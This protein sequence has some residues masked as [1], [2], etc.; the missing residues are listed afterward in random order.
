[1]A[2]ISKVPVAWNGS[3]VVGT[4]YS[5]LYCMAGDEH[6]LMTAFRALLSTCANSF[7]N[8]LQWTF[9]TSGVQLNDTNGTVVGDW[10]DGS[11]VSSLTGGAVTTWVNG[12]GLRIKWST[13]G[14]HDGEFVT[15]STFMVPLIAAAYEGAGN[16]DSGTLSTMTGALTTFVATATLVIWAR[17][18]PGVDGAAIAV[19]GFNLPDRVSWLRSRRT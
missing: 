4:G 5:V 2:V 8:Q 14:V 18:K 19:S 13:G 15:G 11:P 3:A 12:V 17:P 9:P 16:I 10:A 6:A 7:P 1:M